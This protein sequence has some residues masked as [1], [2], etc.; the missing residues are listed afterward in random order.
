MFRGRYQHTIDPKGRLSVP[1]RFREALAQYGEHSDQLV[2]VPERARPGGPSAGGVAADRGEAERPAHV[3][4]GG[5]S[6]LPAVHVARQGRHPRQR[7]PGPAAS[8]H[9]Q[10][11]G[12]R[13]GGHAGRR[14]A[15]DVR[16]V[17]PGALR[18]VRAH[19]RRRAAD[20]VRQAVRRTESSGS[21]SCP[22]GRG[23]VSPAAAKRG[24]GDRRDGGDG[25]TRGGDAGDE[26]QRRTAA[27][28]WTPIP[29]R[30]ARPARAWPGSAPGPA[31]PTP[32]SPTST[33]S[34]PSRVWT[35][36]RRSCSISASPP[37]SS[38]TP[39]AA[40]PFSAKRSRW[41]C[42]WIPPRARPRWT[43]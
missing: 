43:C 17:G 6:A 10:G 20:A 25:R 18:G 24:L 2:V 19:A 28:A 37:G 5:A 9:A 23:R 38:T 14:R 11:G 8:R 1:A 21:R 30:C 40:S 22:R 42:G 27:R 33:R 12:P 36:R 4:A 29:R 41:T 32:A 35:R 16:G 3:H 7:R 26:R 31:W 39:A 13:Q 15:P 34:P